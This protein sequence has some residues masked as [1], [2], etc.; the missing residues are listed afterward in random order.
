M[1]VRS[2]LA[3]LGVLVA[4][5][6]AAA[7]AAPWEQPPS[8]DPSSSP[9]VEGTVVPAAGSFA[10]GALLGWTDDAV[11][12]GTGREHHDLVSDRVAAT[13]TLQAGLGRRVALALQ[14]PVVW[15]QGTEAAS[16]V[17]PSPGGLGDLRAV[18]RWAPLSAGSVVDATAPRSNCSPAT[19]CSRSRGFGVGFDVALTAPTA[20][21]SLAGSGVPTAHVSAAFEYRWYRYAFVVRAG[22]MSRLDALGHDAAPCGSAGAACL[23]GT[24]L[25]DRFTAGIAL[26]Q[27]LSALLA[28]IASGNPGIADVASAVSLFMEYTFG[29]PY[30]SVDMN[31]DP[32]ARYGATTLAFGAGTQRRFG[33]VVVTA[34]WSRTLLREAREADDDRVILGIQWSTGGDEDGD[35]VPDADDRC[36][37][38]RGPAGTHGCPDPAD[39]IGVVIPPYHAPEGSPRVRPMP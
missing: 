16:G 37:G 2:T 9:S 24:P 22:W 32:W 15:G 33:D 29:T 5:S 4:S 35:G 19:S 27:P 8:V 7:Q 21:G 6:R 39:G 1:K 23:A 10:F 18:L 14:L 28:L 36:I 26:R 31:V 30:V 38:V 11:R 17:T 34:G 3:A 13:Y 20:G 25:R 12:V